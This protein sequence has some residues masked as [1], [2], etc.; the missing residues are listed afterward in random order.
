MD[1]R[2]EVWMPGESAFSLSSYLHIVRLRSDILL[3]EELPGEPLSVTRLDLGTIY[4]FNDTARRIW[5]LSREPITV[6]EVVNALLF[7]Y[8]IDRITCESEV[9]GF[10]AKLSKERLIQFGLSC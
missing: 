2:S 5:Q 4:L 8:D 3:E 1:T 7:E 9:F 10:L 6:G